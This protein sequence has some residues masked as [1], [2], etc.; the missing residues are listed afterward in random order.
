[1]QVVSA[2]L[3]RISGNLTYEQMIRDL[4]TPEL[5]IILNDKVVQSPGVRKRRK[6]IDYYGGDTSTHRETIFEDR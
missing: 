3:Y 2:E 4:G 6:I 5:S 1:M